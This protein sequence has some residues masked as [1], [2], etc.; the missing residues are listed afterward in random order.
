[1]AFCVGAAFT[2]SGGEQQLWEVVFKGITVLR[3]YKSFG[4]KG[5]IVYTEV[6]ICS[7]IHTKHLKY[8]VG[9]T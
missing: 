2:A 1:M 7:Q 9:R 4:V 3:L 6:T 8:C 5:L